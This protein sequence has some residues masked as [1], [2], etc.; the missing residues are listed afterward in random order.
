MRTN[1]ADPE[2]KSATN[3]LSNLL[4]NDLAKLMNLEG[5]NNK[6]GFRSLHLYKVFEGKAILLQLVLDICSLFQQLYTLQKCTLSAAASSLFSVLGVV[7][8]CCCVN[9][10]LSLLIY[11]NYLFTVYAV[12]SFM[13]SL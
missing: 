4:Y 11:W 3:L 8:Y 2:R 12:T 13:S 7:C 5:V 9:L 1:V 6:I 10:V